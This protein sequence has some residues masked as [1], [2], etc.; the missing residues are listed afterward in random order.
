MAKKLTLRQQ[1]YLRGLEEGEKRAAEAATR[2]QTVA[3]LF[4]SRGV[5]EVDLA[6][7]RE[8]AILAAK[9]VVP[10]KSAV[11]VN[12]VLWEHK[13]RIK[14]TVHRNTPYNTDWLQEWLKSFY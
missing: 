2:K 1:A 11:P 12:E 13:Y 10:V 5:R 6:E 8:R 3:E 7:E 9:A 14:V 4:L